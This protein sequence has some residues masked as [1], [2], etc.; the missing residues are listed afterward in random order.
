[1]LPQKEIRTVTKVT[2]KQIQKANMDIHGGT[3]QTESISLLGEVLKLA[4]LKSSI[5]EENWCFCNRRL[6]FLVAFR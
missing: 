5:C 1:M 2:L 4:V 3:L 6:L